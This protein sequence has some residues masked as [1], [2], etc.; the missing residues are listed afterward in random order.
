MT[1]ISSVTTLPPAH[2]QSTQPTPRQPSQDSDGDN[3]GSTTA[4][5]ATQQPSARALDITA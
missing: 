5:A 1:P 3:D 4:A 2:I